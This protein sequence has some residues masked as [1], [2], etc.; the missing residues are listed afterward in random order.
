M[1]IDLERF[2]EYCW[3]RKPLNIGNRL[4]ECRRRKVT[5]NGII[6]VYHD[7]RN[8]NPISIIIKDKRSN[9]RRRV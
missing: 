7:R 6:F 3:N 2:K 5:T 8:K 1:R 4:I 9:N